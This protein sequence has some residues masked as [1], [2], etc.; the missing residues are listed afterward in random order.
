[1][2]FCNSCGANLQGGAK[3]CP[4]CGAV[5]PVSGTVP[6]TAQARPPAPVPSLSPSQGSNSALKIIL[7]VVGIFVVVGA[8]AVATIGF[9]GWRIARH[10]HVQDRDGNVRVQ[11][12]FAHTVVLGS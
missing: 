7:I 4:K 2:A 6:A 1:M 11:T 9:I 3:F 5:Q 12:P 10:T 8:L